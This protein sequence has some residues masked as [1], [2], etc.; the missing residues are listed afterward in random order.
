VAATPAD[1]MPSLVT[2]PAELREVDAEHRLK[3]EKYFRPFP[4][5]PI[6]PK[7]LGPFLGLCFTNRSGS[8][9]LAQVMASTGAFNEAEEVFLAETVLDHAVAR[10]MRSLDDYMIFLRHRLAG[11]DDRL[12][13]KLG[14]WQLVM[15]AEIGL[16]PRDARYLLIYRRDLLGQA[17]S[18]S[19]AFQNNHWTSEHPKD[20]SDDALVYSREV[21]AQTIADIETHLNLFEAAFELMGVTPHRVQYEDLVEN[22]QAVVDGIGAWMGMPGL[23]IQPQQIRLRRQANGVNANWRARYLAGE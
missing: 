16:L 13:A 14:L 10:Q 21:I 11:A 3:I 1:E 19:I 7:A 23:R 22:P 8:N 15:L 9:Y 12:T 5:T 18:T 20:R 6:E 17:I 2:F 4:V